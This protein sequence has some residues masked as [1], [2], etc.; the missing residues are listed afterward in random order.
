M[1]ILRHVQ[2]ISNGRIFRSG[3]VVPDNV[4]TRLLVENGQAEIINTG[5]KSTKKPKAE[6]PRENAESDS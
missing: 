5:S 6:T 1:I 3:E 2:F 4:V